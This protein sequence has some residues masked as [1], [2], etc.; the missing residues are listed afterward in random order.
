M[1]ETLCP[2]ILVTTLQLV[3]EHSATLSVA[4]VLVVVWVSLTIDIK[5]VGC[6]TTEITC[7]LYSMLGDFSTGVTDEG[8]DGKTVEDIPAVW[9]KQYT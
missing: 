3:V 4:T 9:F 5:L 1:L 7:W 6:D 8:E 2:L